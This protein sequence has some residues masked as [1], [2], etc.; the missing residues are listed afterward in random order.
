M[1]PIANSTVVHKY[2]LN[3]KDGTFLP[4]ITFMNDAFKTKVMNEI[5]AYAGEG[6]V[7]KIGESLQ[8][9]YKE[10]EDVLDF[11]DSQYAEE[12]GVSSFNLD[13]TTVNL[14]EGDEATMKGSL[15]DANTAVDALKLQFYEDRDSVEAAFGEKLTEDQ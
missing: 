3:Q 6:G 9:S 15:K 2:D 12:K 11:K 4:L 5:N 1:L 8:D 7:A 14:E 13:D 10:L